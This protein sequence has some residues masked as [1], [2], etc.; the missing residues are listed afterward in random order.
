MRELQ[1]GHH[2]AASGRAE[3]RPEGEDK[4]EEHEPEEVVEAHPG[5]CREE[6]AV[7]RNC[8]HRGSPDHAA[9]SPRSNQPAPGIPRVA[10]EG[11]TEPQ[12]PKAAD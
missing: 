4:E 11:S 2:F 10:P 3:P 7:Q 12:G 5:A 1:D 6:D 8:P 9:K